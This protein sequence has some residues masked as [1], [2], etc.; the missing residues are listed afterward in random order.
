MGD[1]TLLLY[2]PY[3]V[4]AGG[5]TFH[6]KGPG[7]AMLS[8][9]DQQSQTANHQIPV[10][11]HMMTPGVVQIPGDVSATEASSLFERERMPCLLVKDTDIRFGLMTP[12]DIVKKVV[13]LGLE[14]DEVEVR[15]IMTM[16]V[17]FIEYDRALEDASML[18]LSANTSILI[19]TKE[20]QPVG[21]LTARDLVLFPKRCFTDIEAMISIIESDYPEPQHAVTIVQLSHVGASVKC[22]VVLIPG[23][24]VLLSFSLPDLVGSMSIQG[25]ILQDDERIQSDIRD[26][27][28]ADQGI[29]IHFINISPGDLARIK[30]WVLQNSRNSS[31]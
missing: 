9:D 28:A 11:A 15:T 20:N 14:P 18:M 7:R 3:I 21:I 12:T 31:N 30:A 2:L 26:R 23:S 27:S 19:V 17:Q 8:K 24:K 13:A 4:A 29:T 10:V 16:P 6:E 22:P 25:R 5:R 1:T